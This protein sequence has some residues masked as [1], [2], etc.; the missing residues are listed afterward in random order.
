MSGQR[1]E[2][3]VESRRVA[4]NKDGILI[5]GHGESAAFPVRKFRLEHGPHFAG[6]ADAGPRCRDGVERAST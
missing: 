1:A 3:P 5:M 4:Q 6:A 2:S